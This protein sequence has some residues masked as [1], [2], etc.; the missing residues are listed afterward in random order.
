[1]WNGETLTN[2]EILPLYMD[3]DFFDKFDKVSATWQQESDNST[4]LPILIIFPISHFILLL[5]LSRKQNT[6]S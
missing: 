1:M 4:R 5:I 3:S 2:L 6:I